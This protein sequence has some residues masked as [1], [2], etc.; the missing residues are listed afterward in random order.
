MRSEWYISALPSNIAIFM[1]R[2]NKTTLV[3]NMKEAIAV[4]KRIIALEKKNAI[5]ECK[6][7]KVSFKEDPKKKQPKDPFDLEGLQKVL[8]TVSNEMV[9]IKKQ[10]AETSSKKPYKLYRRNP[11]IDPKPPNAITSTE[12]EE[13]EEEITTDVPTDEEE[14]VELQGMWDF[15]LLD[16]EDQEASLV[17]T[18]SRNELDPPQSTPKPKSA[19]STLK[20]KVAAKKTT[21]KA[22]QTSPIQ[23]G[24]PTTSKT[25]I[26]SDEMEYNIIEDMKKTR[27][28]IT[29]YE[30]SKLKH[31][32]KLLLKELHAI[33][34]AP[35]H[36]TVILK[37]SHEMGRPPNTVINKV[38]PNDISLIGGRS[39]SHTIPFLLTYENF[40]KILHNCLVDLGASSNIL[41]KSIC[42]KLN[43]QPQKSV[44][45]IV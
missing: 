38:D 12:S 36:A 18:R 42:A 21:S 2:A 1:D 14:F 44:V 39:R 29:F 9:D 25:L 33:P 8:K 20:D 15:I 34:V 10:V 41:P 26:V 22:T 24:S 4:E 17:S 32:Q 13:E 40:N 35:L 31:Q 28:N 37:A 7:K 27:A 43:V 6:S 16:E 5:E 11:S 23:A 19:S 3:D 30:L 45:R